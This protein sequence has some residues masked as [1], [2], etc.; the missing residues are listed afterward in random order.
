[1]KAFSIRVTNSRRTNFLTL[2]LVLVVLVMAAQPVLAKNGNARV[3]PPNAHP[4]GKTINEWTAEWWRYVLGFPAATNPL[5]DST[6]ADCAAGQSGHVFFLVGTAGKDP[7]VR[8]DCVVPV[9]KAILFPVINVMG[10]VPDD[11]PTAEALIALVSGVLDY[12]D[13]VEVTVDGVSLENLLADYRFPSPVFSFDGAVPGIYSPQYE[14]PRAAAFSD[15]WW[16]ML[17][18]LPPGSHTIH[19]SGHFYWPEGNWDFAPEVTYN[20]TVR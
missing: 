20:L 3:F 15:G 7:V 18:P 10:A 11:E 6:G 2:V 12:T 14:G 1:M 9:G 5:A 8:N 19:L 16:V 17:P 13:K 4:Y